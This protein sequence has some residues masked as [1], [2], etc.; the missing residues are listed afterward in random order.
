MYGGGIRRGPDAALTAPWDLKKLFTIADDATRDAWRIEC[1]RVGP[2]LHR[3]NIKVK[4]SLAGVT[5]ASSSMTTSSAWR[6]HLNSIKYHSQNIERAQKKKKNQGGRSKGKGKEELHAIFS[7]PETMQWARD[8]ATLKRGQPLLKSLFGRMETEYQ[9]VL[10]KEKEIQST[11]DKRRLYVAEN[12]E[13]LTEIS[14]RSTIVRE[15]VDRVGAGVSDTSPLQKIRAA[16][17]SIQGEI[18]LMDLRTG[19]LSTQILSKNK[20]GVKKINTYTRR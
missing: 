17:R 7:A 18:R 19:V 11:V 10:K 14:E 9:H 2:I 8:L 4:K 16:L 1:E 5:G 15:E 13:K 3:T 20:R 6:M 12:S